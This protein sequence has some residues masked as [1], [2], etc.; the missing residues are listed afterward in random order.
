MKSKRLPIKCYA[1]LYQLP[2]MT[3]FF[4]NYLKSFSFILQDKDA[5]KSKQK[6]EKKKTEKKEDNVASKKPEKKS[7][8][9]SENDIRKNDEL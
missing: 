6:E 4:F 9:K 7:A 1:F 8:K 3:A 2:K 5:D